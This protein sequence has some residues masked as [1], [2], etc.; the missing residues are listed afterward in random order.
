MAGADLKIGVR[1]IGSLLHEGRLQ[2]PFNQ[3]SYAWREKH[4]RNLLQDLD[5]E[6]SRGDGDEYFLGTIVLIQKGSEPPTIVDGQ[7]RLA[8]VSILLARI[9]DQLAKL[10][11]GASAQSIEESFLTNI[12]RKTELRVARL[13]LNLEDNAFYLDKILPPNVEVAQLPISRSN[14]RLLRASRLIAEKCEDLIKDRSLDHQTNTLNKWVDFI[15]EKAAV[16]L[17]VAPDEVSAFRMFE[18]LNDRG[19]KVSQSD[20]LKNYFFS[21]AAGRASEAQNMWSKLVSVIETIGSDDREEKEFDDEEGIDRHDL[22][23]TYIRHLWVTEHG[24]T[25]A[26]LLADKIKADVNNEAKSLA[27]LNDAQ[28]AAVDYA[29]LW[30]SQ[31]PKWAK[32]KST[33]RQNV[34]TIANHLRVEQIRPL[35]FAV[36]RHFKPDEADKAF[37]LFVS[38][39]VRF[40]IFGGR[41]GMLD[42][43][44][45]LRAMEVGTKQ[46]TKASELSEKMKPYVPTDIEFVEAFTNARVSR[47]H[48]ARYYL[49]ALEKTSKEL[50]Q[51]E[52]VANED[53]ADISLEHV[54]PLNPGKDWTVADDAAQA[55]QKLLGN[56]V[57]IRANQNREIGNLGFE[58]KRDALGKSGYDLTKQV[59]KYKTWTRDDIRDRQAQLAKL[60]VKTWPV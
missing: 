18:T 35:L 31:S 38:W 6:I 48:L 2:V 13:Q 14:R 40:L 43:Q 4:V 33:T 17:I 32:Y 56:M 10:N 46:I 45:S 59:A 21:R 42:T 60:A 15:E 36:A 58:A 30:N 29:A 39:S 26:R 7:Q 12:D 1:A 50:P 3:R 20:I 49:R 52:Y 11:R 19:L 54:L 23:V 53:V 25:K 22:L 44:Y 24:P 57:L 51:P 27:F 41:G 37:K 47:T 55:A 8:T 5:E 9:R 34:E 28:S 16:F